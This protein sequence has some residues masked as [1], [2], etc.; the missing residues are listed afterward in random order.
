[1]LVRLPVL[2]AVAREKRY[3]VFGVRCAVFGGGCSVFGVGFSRGWAGR[4]DGDGLFNY[5]AG[6]SGN[7][8]GGTEG[9]GHA[10]ELASELDQR[11][12]AVKTR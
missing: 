5:M 2:L 3:S 6:F 4:S 11:W 10:R 8:R 1:L 12:L 9:R 7:W